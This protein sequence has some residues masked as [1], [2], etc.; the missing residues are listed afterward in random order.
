MNLNYVN[1]VP[2]ATG[3][4]GVKKKE[5]MLLRKPAAFAG[6]FT[7]PSVAVAP[8]PPSQAPQLLLFRNWGACDGG[9]CGYISKKKLAG[10]PT[11][12]GLS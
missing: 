12:A 3:G 5:E 1:K 11:F 9:I 10:L 2:F 7:A 4:L 8:R 6:V